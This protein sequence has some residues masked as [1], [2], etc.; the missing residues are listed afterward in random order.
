MSAARL[1]MLEFEHLE[2]GHRSVSRHG[3]RRGIVGSGSGLYQAITGQ[4]SS[5]GDCGFP[6]FL[7][8][9][10]VSTDLWRRFDWRR[11]SSPGPLHL[12][13][14]WLNRLRV[15]FARTVL[16]GPW[17]GACAW[18]TVT[19]GE[20]SCSSVVGAGVAA[21]TECHRPP[22]RVTMSSCEH[23]RAPEAHPAT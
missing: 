14:L 4:P 18:L 3:S 12:T 15:V 16:P 2:R 1:N 19:R 5:T 20:T 21:A 17:Q 10:R 9:S 6:R 23:G 22:R 7:V 11:T 13:H 8:S